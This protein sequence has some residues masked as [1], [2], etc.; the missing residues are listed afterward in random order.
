MNAFVLSTPLTLSTTSSF[1]QGQS[2]SVIGSSVFV[3]PI[4][5]AV[6]HAHLT[7]APSR[8]SPTMQDD[9]FPE[10]EETQREYE[11]NKLFVGN[12]SWGTTGE[13]LSAAFEEFGQVVSA[14]VIFDRETGRSRGFG[15]IEFDTAGE[16]SEALAQVNGTYIDGR[17]V[18]VDRVFKKEY[19]PRPRTPME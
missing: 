18:R 7:I 3:A 15:F 11:E 13:S 16:A 8:K 19:T 5:A 2:R 6:R 12:L 17:R 4:R 9:L 1:A 10:E 14:K